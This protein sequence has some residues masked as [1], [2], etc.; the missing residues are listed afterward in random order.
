MLDAAAPRQRALPE[1][2]NVPRRVDVGVAGAQERIDHDPVV[3][4]QSGRQREI[5]VGPGADPSHDPVDFDVA[6]GRAVHAPVG[7][8]E[9]LTALDHVGDRGA[10]KHLD[11]LLAVVGVEIQG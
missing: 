6:G 7:E 9:T 3:D 1:S 4:R 5:D 10:G 11:S 2:R 8:N